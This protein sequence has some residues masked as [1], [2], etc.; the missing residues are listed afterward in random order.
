M[1]TFFRIQEKGITLDEMQKFSSGDGGDGMEEKGGICACDSV[2]ELIN[3]RHATYGDEIVI[4][5][6]NVL[7]K[8]YDGYRVEPVEILARF[9]VVDMYE[10]KKELLYEYE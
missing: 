6:G 9:D 3:A 8:I 1:R 7:C 5:K 4:F 10:E 2:T